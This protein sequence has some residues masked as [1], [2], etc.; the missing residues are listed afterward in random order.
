M[1][2]TFVNNTDD[3]CFFKKGNIHGR[4]NSVGHEVL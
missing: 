1:L 4:K 2:T 3:V